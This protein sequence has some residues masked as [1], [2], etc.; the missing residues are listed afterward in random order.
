MNPIEKR[1]AKV[2]PKLLELMEHRARL[3]NRPLPLSVDVARVRKK[4]GMSQEL[5]ARRFGFPV[6]TLR[7]WERR[8]RVPRGPA[9]V[10]LTVISRD[11]N[12]VCVRSRGN[13]GTISARSQRFE[14]IPRSFAAVPPSIAIF[15]ASLAPGAFMTTSTALLSHGYGKSEPTRTRS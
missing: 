4:T 11:P 10:L 8:D 12:A 14:S 3:G 9:L 15:C 2:S 13:C 5:F 7:H 6:A 1:L